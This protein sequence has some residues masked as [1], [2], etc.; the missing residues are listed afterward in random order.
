MTVE[1]Q[2]AGMRLVYIGQAF[3]AV[4]TQLLMSSAIGVLL[5]K[6][7]GGSDLQ[8]MLLAPVFMVSRIL[9]IPISLRVPPSRGKRFMLR[10]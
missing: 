2:R 1:R 9:Q 6:H 7:L 8:A 10:S 5:I 4:Q 3:G